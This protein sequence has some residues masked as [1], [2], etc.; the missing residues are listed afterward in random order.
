VDALDR[1][2]VECLTLAQT[3]ETCWAYYIQSDGQ[4]LAAEC[5]DAVRLFLQAQDALA[6]QDARVADPKC[7]MPAGATLGPGA[8]SVVNPKAVRASP[9][10][11]SAFSARL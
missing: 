3:F 9:S 1:L 2:R 11:V 4:L 6:E 7:E 5:R 8:V 10:K